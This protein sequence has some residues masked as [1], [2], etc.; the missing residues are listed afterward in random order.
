MVEP[1]L[2]DSRYFTRIKVIKILL[3]SAQEQTS[4]KVLY[5]AWLWLIEKLA[6]A[7]SK[8]QVAQTFMIFAQKKQP[9]GCF[10][11]QWQVNHFLH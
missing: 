4:F 7:L 1:S 9:E 11:F 2:C 5:F 3:R 6:I 10:L 8:D